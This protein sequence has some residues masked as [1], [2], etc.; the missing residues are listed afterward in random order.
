ML[1]RR[2][3]VTYKKTTDH[4]PHTPTQFLCC[5]VRRP[6]G[7]VTGGQESDV[8]VAVIHSNQ[9]FPGRRWDG[10]CHG[11]LEMFDSMF[12]GGSKVCRVLREEVCV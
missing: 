5:D 10:A 8:P 3:R 4:P 7:G 1:S 12:F 6:F 11:E 9:C 2:L